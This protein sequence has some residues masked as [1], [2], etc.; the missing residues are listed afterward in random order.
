[1]LPNIYVALLH[2]SYRLQIILND[3]FWR[4]PLLD[5]PRREP[6][7]MGAALAQLIY[8]VAQSCCAKSNF[9]VA[10]FVASCVRPNGLGCDKIYTKY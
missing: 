6:V 3:L 7:P 2:A 9:T 4:F 1:M 8:G 10:K 5:D